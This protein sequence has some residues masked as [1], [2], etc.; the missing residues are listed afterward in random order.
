MIAGQKV[1]FRSKFPKTRYHFYSD[2]V[3]KTAN[4]DPDL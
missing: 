2:Y 1:C 3:D 4:L